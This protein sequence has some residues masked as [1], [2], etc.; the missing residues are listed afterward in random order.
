SRACPGSRVRGIRRWECLFGLG[1]SVHGERADPSLALETLAV[2]GWRGL[3]IRL[4]TLL[5]LFFFVPEPFDK[6]LLFWFVVGHQQ[7]A[8]AASADKMANFF[9]QVL[10]MVARAFQRL[11]H[12]NNLQ[13]GEVRNVLR[14]LDVAQE[15]DI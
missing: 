9:G 4:W 13:A 3:P 12:E 15:D 5:R 7:V 11:R 8:N 14:I 2:K 6:H 10:G 1:G